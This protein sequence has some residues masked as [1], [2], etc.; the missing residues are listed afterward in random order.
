MGAREAAEYLGVS[1]RALRSL[2]DLGQLPA[3]RFD[4]TVR[5]RAR[6]LEGF[7]GSARVL[8]PVETGVRPSVNRAGRRPNGAD[9]LDALLAEGWTLGRIAIAIGALPQ[10]A[11][12]WPTTGVPNR[13][14]KA[15]RKLAA[16]EEPVP[17]SFGRPRQHPLSQSQLEAHS[18]AL[19]VV[20]EAVTAAEHDLAMAVRRRSIQIQ[21]AR[22]A[23]LTWAE[24]AHALGLPSGA[25]ARHLA[26]QPAPEQRGQ[27]A[28]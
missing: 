22:G 26:R 12:A 4:G 13:W 7:S 5:L 18:T 11:E 21:E 9:A 2:V 24:I 27:G 3:Y 16:G 10:R 1:L 20:G 6:D 14:V 23:G 28:H 17:P 19:R 15:V 8:V 25:R